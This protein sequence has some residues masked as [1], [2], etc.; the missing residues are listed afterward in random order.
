M[1]VAASH[2]PSRPGDTSK[3][4]SSMVDLM[5]T[6]SYI[7]GVFH[8]RER[9]LLQRYVDSVLAL[10]DQ[11]SA[12]T[13]ADRARLRDAWRAHVDER[14]AKLEQEIAVLAEE[15]LAA[16]AAGKDSY[17]GSRLRVRAVTLFREMSAADQALALEL[18]TALVHADGQITQNERNLQAEL[19]GLFTKQPVRAPVAEP[20]ARTMVSGKTS[21]P[22]I[23]IAPYGRMN[24]ETL[25]HPLLDPIEQT[26]SPHPIE[27][28]AQ[29]EWE[30]QLVQKAM[31]AWQRQRVLGANR[32]WRT[33]MFAPHATGFDR[34]S[35]S[36]D[37]AMQP[38][39]PG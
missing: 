10:I 21:G 24:L 25:S 36:S 20:N 31:L 19:N 17:V 32:L 15:V 12:G 28:K 13:P 4:L 3:Q 6:V 30:Y 7:D 5:L 16:A 1:E 23:I 29:V 11:A 33:I 26:L 14:Y 34:C 27:R 2:A 8:H 38:G 35:L 18:V 22:P 37:A 9:D 39:S